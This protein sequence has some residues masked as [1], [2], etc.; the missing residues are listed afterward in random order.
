MGR[1]VPKYD[2]SHPLFL[3]GEGLL[4]TTDSN[5]EFLRHLLNN[6]KLNHHR[7]LNK[8]TLEKMF[9]NIGTKDEHGINTGFGLFITGEILKKYGKGYSGL[10]QGGGYESTSFW[11]DP[12]RKFVGLLMTQANQSPDKAGLGSGVYD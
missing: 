12:K 8:E 7:F 4:A 1:N 5:S 6:G 2:P 10:L 11:I 3:A 9:S